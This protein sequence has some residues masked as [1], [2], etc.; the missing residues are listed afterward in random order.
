MHYV[1]K[2]NDCTYI[3]RNKGGHDALLS[4]MAVR[5]AGNDFPYH[6]KV[7]GLGKMNLQSAVM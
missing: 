7:K 2:T 3:K 1:M 6:S 4:G 5:N